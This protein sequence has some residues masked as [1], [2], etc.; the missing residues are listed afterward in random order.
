[1]ASSSVM[2][3][4]ADFVKGK[5]T[6]KGDGVWVRVD[7]PSTI[8]DPLVFLGSPDFIGNYGIRAQVRFYH[9]FTHHP[10]F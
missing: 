2:Y 9:L 10:G 5:V 7:F 1:M 3:I 8:T 4:N 6:V